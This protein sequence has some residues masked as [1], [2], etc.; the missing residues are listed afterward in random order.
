M[1]SPAVFL[2]LIV[3]LVSCE[4]NDIHRTD[5]TPVKRESVYYNETG[6]KISEKL[7]DY[8]DQ[9][10]VLREVTNLIDPQYTDSEILY[11]YD[12]DGH[13]VKKEEGWSGNYY[14]TEFTYKNGLIDRS[15]ASSAD[16]MYVNRTRYFYSSNLLD[17]TY[18]ESYY[19]N[20]TISENSWTVRYQ[21]DE[22]G[23]LIKTGGQEFEYDSRGKVAWTC[24]GEGGPN[25]AGMCYTNEFNEYDQL[26]KTFLVIPG[27]SAPST[28]LQEEYFYK[29]G[30][31]DEKRMYNWFYTR[32]PNPPDI[33]VIKY[34]Y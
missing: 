30:R 27:S 17:S 33:N 18:T 6:E 31:L 29:D 7:F 8:D 24:F 16:N 15:V 4:Y 14:T 3:L 12:S 1:R 20:G 23:R 2:T 22:Q 28:Y 10:R 19:N 5:N 9:N 32:T 25:V 26:V 21:Y 34:E 11:H 13:L